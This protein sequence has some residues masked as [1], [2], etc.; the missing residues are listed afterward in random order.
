[1]KAYDRKII[2]KR[3]TIIVVLTIILYSILLIYTGL[4]AELVV[5]A[6]RLIIYASIPTILAFILKGIRFNMIV[7]RFVREFKISL[8]KGII[9]RLAS[10]VFSFIG[11]SYLGDEL[12]RYYLL[13][14]YGVD[15]PKAL[16]LS[17]LEA[18]EETIVAFS[19]VFA[20]FIL[21]YSSTMKN[22]YF[23]IGLVVSMLILIVNIM[24]LL[25][26]SRVVNLIKFI[27]DKMSRIFS[28]EIDDEV[29]LRWSREL[30]KY[31]DIIF[32][33]KISILVT[34][35]VS[36]LIGVSSGA[37][38]YIILN[39]VG[40]DAS[41][42]TSI[43]MLYLVLTISALPITIGGVGV[44]ELYLYL[45]GIGLSSGF[46]LV[47]TV[48]FRISSYY[49]PFILILICFIYSIKEVF[50]AF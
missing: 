19:F 2:Y 26:V 34:L 21:N 49:I 15:S 22:I 14:S 9:L 13:R 45:L 6:P 4:P 43:Y 36:Y 16:L 23:Q 42:L 47:Y 37:S 46:N 41:L 33:D 50:K 27:I 44:S 25:N 3:V 8:S 48:I 17:Y 1:M 35:L 29:F 31:R 32:S 24:V 12:Y 38:L 40:I 18:F 20:G 5:E 10:E 11:V 28:R 7:R 39:S 30:P